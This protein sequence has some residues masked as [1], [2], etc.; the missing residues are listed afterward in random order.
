MNQ[1]ELTKTSIMTSNQE[2]HVDLYNLYTHILALCRL[3]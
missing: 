2:K 3:G 1:K